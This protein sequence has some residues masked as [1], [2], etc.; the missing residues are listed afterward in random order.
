MSD[1]LSCGAHTREHL[2]LRG[3]DVIWM[4]ADDFGLAHDSGIISAEL[5]KVK[6]F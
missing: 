1:V 3:V 2:Y 6:P 5:G 4:R